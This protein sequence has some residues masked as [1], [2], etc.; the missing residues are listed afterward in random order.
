MRCETAN[1]LHAEAYSMHTGKSTVKRLRKTLQLYDAQLQSI[2]Q[3]IKEVIAADALL[4]EKINK[5]TTIKGV[6]VLTAATVVAETNGFAL[7][8]NQKQLVSYAGYDVV[9]NQSGNRVGRT[10]ISKQGNSHIR[11]ILHMPALHAMRRNVPVCRALFDRLT[12]KG[13]KKMLAYVAVQKKLLVLIY[14]LWKRDEAWQ[15]NKQGLLQPDL[16]EDIPHLSAKSSLSGKV[17][18]RKIQLK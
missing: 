13:K 8:T 5:V 2:R 4:Q 3:E 9:E 6:G 17:K 10:R 18:I 14:T 1:R 16:E 11:R 7:F 12:G 15:E